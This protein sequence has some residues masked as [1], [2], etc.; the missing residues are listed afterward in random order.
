MHDKVLWNGRRPLRQLHL[1][2]A[3]RAQLIPLLM[4]CLGPRAS[5]GPSRLPPDA[6]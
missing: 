2:L 5:S 6:S 3:E 4:L 1:P